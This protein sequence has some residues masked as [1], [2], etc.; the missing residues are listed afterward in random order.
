MFVLFFFFFKQ[1][2]FINALHKRFTIKSQLIQSAPE[3]QI[4][5]VNIRMN[6]A[7]QPNDI[8][9]VSNS[10]FVIVK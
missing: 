7:D 1:N 4:Y 6:P 3:E 5:T 9:I 8:N 10:S 2:N